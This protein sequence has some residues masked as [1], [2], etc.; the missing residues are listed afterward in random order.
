MKFLLNIGLNRGIATVAT[1]E[2]KNYQTLFAFAFSTCMSF[3]IVCRGC[4][5]YIVCRVAVKLKY[6]CVLNF[7]MIS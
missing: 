5:A 7:E 4:A 2:W 6:D 3:F 1:V